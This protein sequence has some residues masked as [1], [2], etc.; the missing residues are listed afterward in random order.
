MLCLKEPIL[1]KPQ[2]VMIANWSQSHE[3]ASD[4][5]LVLYRTYKKTTV[6]TPTIKNATED[7]F[8]PFPF[9]QQSKNLGIN[10]IY[11]HVIKI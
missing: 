4:V 9:A 1:P 11:K 5:I 7:F 10:I 3:S 8:F 6:E 2:T